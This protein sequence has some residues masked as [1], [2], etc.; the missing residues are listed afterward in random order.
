MIVANSNDL[1]AAII[2]L[3]V[4]VLPVATGVPFDVLR[5]IQSYPTF[6]RATWVGVIVFLL[7]KKYTL[8]AIVLLALGMI[9]RF[10]VFSSFV[11]SQEGILAQYAA[12]QRNDPRVDT[13]RQLD[14]L[15]AD[16]ALVRDPA[17]WLDSG[18]KR[19]PLLLY[20]PSLDQLKMIGN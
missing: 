8:T 12:A 16:N 20:P 1:Y 18:R 17:R 10:E 19:A 2:T 15:I 13:S 11:Y 4:A 5:T 3:C 14:L 6:V 7:W 9:L